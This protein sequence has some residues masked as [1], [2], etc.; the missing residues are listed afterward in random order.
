MRVPA[1]RRLV[2]SRPRGPIGRGN[3]LKIGVLWV[4][5][6]PGVQ[7]SGVI[8]EA[9]AS[10]WNSLRVWTPRCAAR[11]MERF[12]LVG[13]SCDTRGSTSLTKEEKWPT[14]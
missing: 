2:A 12:P 8:D 7:T 4:R 3:R 14:R 6:P 11:I 9:V 13:A 1:S 5:V 10:S